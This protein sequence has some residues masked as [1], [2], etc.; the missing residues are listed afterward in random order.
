M[1]SRPRLSIEVL[2]RAG[3]L[4]QYGV[5]SASGISAAASSGWFV[6]VVAGAIG[7]NG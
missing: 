7:P 4:P 5:L 1:N 2:A 6:Q 3:T